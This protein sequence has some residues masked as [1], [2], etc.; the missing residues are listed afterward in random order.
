MGRREER[1]AGCQGPGRGLCLTAWSKH[2]ERMDC[3][4]VSRGGVV[5][6]DPLPP[7]NTHPNPMTK[8]RTGERM[9][10]LQAPTSNNQGKSD[11]RLQHAAHG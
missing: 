1:A 4:L 10:Q 6:S 5:L 11:E 9:K 2:A 8:A 7:E 3:G